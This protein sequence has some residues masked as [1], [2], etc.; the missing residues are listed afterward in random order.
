MA[1]LPG[2]EF[3]CL[4]HNHKMILLCKSTKILIERRQQLQLRKNNKKQDYKW[5][6][7]S[8]KKT[9]QYSQDD[10]SRDPMFILEYLIPV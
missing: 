8:H 10:I 5:K 9:L 7:V 6:T 2:F 1:L 3:Y 4:F